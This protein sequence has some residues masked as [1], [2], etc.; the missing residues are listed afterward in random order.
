MTAE[1]VNIEEKI[2][3][4][5]VGHLKGSTVRKSPDVVQ[6]HKIE[7]PRELVHQCDDLILFIDLFYVN[8]LPMLTSIDSP[9]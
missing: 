8:G 2:F 5:D 7:I 3:A 9:I 4:K 1:D 6:D